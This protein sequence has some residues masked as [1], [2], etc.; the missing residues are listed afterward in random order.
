MGF[1]ILR[2]QNQIERKEYCRIHTLSLGFPSSAEH[3]ARYLIHVSNF[4]GLYLCEVTAKVTNYICTFEIV[5]K[6]L[7]CSQPFAVWARAGLRNKFLSPIPQLLSGSSQLR[8]PYFNDQV[9]AS[10]LCEL[11][12]SRQQR[13][14]VRKGPRAFI[15]NIDDSHFG[16]VQAR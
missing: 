1:P 2:H 3:M 10:A 13:P 8:I 9:R 6:Q 4:G 11:Y 15:S 16:S 7:V 5:G 14:K 12:A